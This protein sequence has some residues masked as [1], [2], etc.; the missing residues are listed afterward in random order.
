[1]IVDDL[2]KDGE[3]LEVSIIS[4]FFGAD[5]WLRVPTYERHARRSELTLVTQND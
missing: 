5:A 3:C 4:G 1:M 2:D